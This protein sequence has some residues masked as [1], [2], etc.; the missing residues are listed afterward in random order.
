MNIADLKAEGAGARVMILG[1]PGAGKTGSLA[2]LANAGYKIRMIDF[3]A[4]PQPFVQH[5]DPR[6]YP[7]VDIIQLGDKMMK[8]SS[9]LEPDGIP[10]A[11]MR[12][13][14]LMNRWKYKAR[15][16]T[17]TDLGPTSAWG[18]DT[19][20]VL[21]SLT[22]LGDAIFRRQA[23]LMNKSPDTMTDRVWGIAMGQQDGFIEALKSPLNRFHLIVLAHLKI[24]GPPD[25]R[26]K[27]NPVTRELKERL[28]DLVPTR[29]FP[30]AL[31]RDLPQSIARHFST[32]VL[33]ETCDDKKIVKSG[34][35][36]AIYT[37]PR[38]E[39][40]LKVPGD[41]PPVLDLADGMAYI[42]KAIAPPLQA[43]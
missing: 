26:D 1:Y 39:L 30:R 38:K 43:A 12:A 14:E 34:C 20:V 3:D 22:S 2:S 24:I 11:Y 17:E 33:C 5:V 32:V 25:V 23:K 16:G 29:L 21:D 8:G 37:T 27:E 6:F 18:S 28:V 42:F 35:G 15:D 19:I 10:T 31:G 9:Y 41:V 36:R 13:L 7:N 4:N 40:D